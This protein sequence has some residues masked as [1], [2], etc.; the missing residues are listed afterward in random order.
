MCV[1]MFSNL[2]YQKLNTKW[3]VLS[4]NQ[5]VSRLRLTLILTSEYLCVGRVEDVTFCFLEGIKYYPAGE[6]IV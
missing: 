3:C 1:F 2:L 5:T 6:V 4:K